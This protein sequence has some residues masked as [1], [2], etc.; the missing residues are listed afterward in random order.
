MNVPNTVIMKKVIKD[1]K[2]Y[3]PTASKVDPHG[4]EDVAHHP[5]FCCG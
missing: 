1:G 5:V 3:T 2:I 4:G